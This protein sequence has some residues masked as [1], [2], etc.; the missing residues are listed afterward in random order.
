MDGAIVEAL[1]VHAYMVGSFLVSWV[2]G[3][4]AAPAGRWNALGFNNSLPATA[5]AY[6]T[7]ELPLAPFTVPASP[8]A[9]DGFNNA[10]DEV[11]P[12]VS[13][14]HFVLSSALTFNS[15]FGL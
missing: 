11:N 7:V 2:A 13:G 10:S 15:L 3:E 1:K 8:D 12:S 14:H 6:P 9:T 5:T 4:L